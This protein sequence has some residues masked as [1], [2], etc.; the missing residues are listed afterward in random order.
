MRW[1][2]EVRLDNEIAGA[3]RRGI[4]LTESRF[5]NGERNTVSIRAKR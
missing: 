2:S 5:F 4:G 1:R 3:K